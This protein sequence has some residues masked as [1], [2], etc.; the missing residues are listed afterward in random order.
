MKNTGRLSAHSLHARIEDSGLSPSTAMT[1][2]TSQPALFNALRRAYNLL[3]KYSKKEYVSPSEQEE[4]FR[5]INLALS[6]ADEG[7]L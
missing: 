6:F 2:W 3:S 1:R 4:I 7:R 5:R